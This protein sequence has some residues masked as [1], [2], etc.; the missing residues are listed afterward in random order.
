MIDY[1]SDLG[2]NKDFDLG[3]KKIFYVAVAAV[4]HKKG[5]NGKF[6][7]FSR[8]KGRSIC[9]IRINQMKNYSD[10]YVKGGW[11]FASRVDVFYFLH[12]ENYVF[13]VI[14]ERENF[15]ESLL[16]EAMGIKKKSNKTNRKW[17]K[18]NETVV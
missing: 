5:K 11:R 1:D 4:S 13:N 2:G 9:S 15:I 3:G 10:K 8:K 6:D 14:A 16:D 18:N 17:T 12:G 7:N